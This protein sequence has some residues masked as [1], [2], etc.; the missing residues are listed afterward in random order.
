[1]R[2][3]FIPDPYSFLH[4]FGF[5]TGMKTY[6]LA[7]VLAGAVVVAQLTSCAVQP[8]G[9]GGMQVGIDNAELF[10]TTIGTFELPGGQQGMLRHDT[11]ANT[12]SVKLG[13]T[14]RVVPLPNVIAASISHVSTVGDRTVAVIETRERSC[15]YRYVVMAV[16][17][18][19]VLQWNVGNCRDRPLVQLAESGRAL[20]L[21][22]PASRQIDRYVYA[23]QRLVRTAL[24]PRPSANT[25]PYQAGIRVQAD[26]IP[27]R[28]RVIPA[29]PHKAGTVAIVSPPAPRQATKRPAG[30]GG[31]G[32]LPGAMTI[33]ADEIKPVRI[34]LRNK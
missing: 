19:D 27:E 12:F 21:D 16:R 33:P 26:T 32:Q 17:A 34:D 23:D 8:N 20:Y 28:A 31:T 13:G 11:T 9:R 2:F 24:L 4:E 1:L 5:I 15:Q 29:P 7:Q 10:G 30:G 25:D 14:M 18:G 22:F 6:T 3:R